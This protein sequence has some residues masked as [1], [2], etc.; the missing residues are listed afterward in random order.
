MPQG[1]GPSPTTSCARSTR[2]TPICGGRPVNERPVP[3]R[4]VSVA[5]DPFISTPMDISS[6]APATVRVGTICDGD[7]SRTDSTTTSQASPASGS[8]N[9]RQCCF[10][11]FAA[12]LESKTAPTIQYRDFSLKVHERAADADRVIKAQVELTYR[13]NLHCVHCYTDP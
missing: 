10:N 6:C 12:M 13:C 1:G 7:C 5:C 2:R 3:H 8:R 4:P 11:R 9:P